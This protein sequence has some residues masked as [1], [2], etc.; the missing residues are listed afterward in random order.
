MH[1]F[2][3]GAAITDEKAKNW[4]GIAGANSWG[5]SKY[6]YEERIEWSKTEGKALARQI[7]SNP[8]S[9]ISIWSKAEEPFQFLAWCLDFNELLEQ[10]YG[11]V[12][13]HPVLLDGT[14]NGFQHFAAMS[15]DNKLAAKVNLK[16]YDEVEDLY[17]EVKDQVIQELSK[18]ADAIAEDW[19]KHHQV[20]TRKMIKK[21]VM[22]IPYSGKTF[23][24]TNAIRDYFM[25]SDEELSWQKDCFL[26][27][28]YLAKIIEKS[29]NNICPKCII[30]MKYLAE[31]ARCFGKEDKDMTWITP[32]KFYVKQHYYKSNVKRIATKLHATTVQL[33]LNCNTTEVDR[34]KSTQSFAANFVHS[35][36]AANVHLALEKSKASGLNQF[37]TIHDCF[38]SPAAHIEEFIGYVKESFVDMYSKNL[39]EDLYQQAVEQLDDPDKLPIPPDIGDFDVCE[40]LLAPYV[41]S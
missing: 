27:N 8:E 24:I 31:I 23:G 6:S 29:V 33:S 10:G 16:N 4:L 21:P 14:N 18:K 38:G 35:L 2:A 5:M 20:I 39:L 9:Y 22:M 37:C 17:E 13:K 12:S 15:L 34:R 40:V 11:Y 28:H 41:F 19:Y 3:E 26:H 30:V 7:A 36:D 32:S 25:G 1:R